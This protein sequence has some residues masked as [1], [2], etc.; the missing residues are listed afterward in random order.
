MLQVF[1]LFRKTYTSYLL[2]LKD[3]K[4]IKELMEFI[5]LVISVVSL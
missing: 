4:K 5:E 3:Q 1:L 2:I